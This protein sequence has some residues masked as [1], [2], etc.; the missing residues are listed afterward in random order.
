[1]TTDYFFPVVKSTLTCSGGAGVK[2]LVGGAVLVGVGVSVGG[3]V[4][5]G[6]GVSVGVA[7]LVGVEVGN[8]LAWGKGVV[9]AV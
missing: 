1:L 3:A 8:F 2:V 7:V 9:V 6:V 5:V 4:L